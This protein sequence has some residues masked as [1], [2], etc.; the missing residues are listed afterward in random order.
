VIRGDA[1]MAAAGDLGDALAKD[2]KVKISRLDAKRSLYL[3][4]ATLK[5]T[6]STSTRC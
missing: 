4:R 5:E 2:G 1:Q 6:A 3:G